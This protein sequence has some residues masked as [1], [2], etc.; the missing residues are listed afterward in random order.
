MNIE[1]EFLKFRGKKNIFPH[2][3]NYISYYEILKEKFDKD[4]HPEVKSK[5]LE[6]EKSGYYN[7]HG[8]DHIKMVIDRVSKII[9]CLNPTFKKEKNKYHITPYELFILLMAINLHDTGHLIASRADHAKAGKSLLAKFDKDN[10]LSAAEK[11]I[12]GNIAQAHGGKDDPIGKLEKVM[13]LSHQE[14][15]PQFLAALLRLGDELAED[16]TR[17]SGFLLEIGQIEKTS[18]IFHLYS[19]SLNSVTLNSNEISLDFYLT[20]K[21]L[22]RAFE[23]QTNEGIVEEYIINEIYTRT[24]KTLLES[25]YCSR[26]LPENARFNK[27]KVKINLLKLDSHEEIMPAIGYKLKEN[28]YP[29]ITEED[30]YKRCES[31]SIMGEKIDGKYVADLIKEQE[32]SRK[33]EKS[34]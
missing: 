5:I 18:V 31:L 25:L 27:V 10:L 20:D 4:V 17:A 2:D 19:A 15:R 6:I 16:E 7:D 28:G 13:N 8:I 23:K 26:F 32:K 30:I 12:I 34:I 1:E 24:Q 22:D 14:I 11:T 3:K 21:Y 29:F 33:N 9:E